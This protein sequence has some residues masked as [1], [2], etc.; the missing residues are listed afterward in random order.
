MAVSLWF[1]ADFQPFYS[2]FAVFGQTDPMICGYSGFSALIFPMSFTRLTQAKSTNPFFERNNGFHIRKKSLS[3][4]NSGLG[5]LL[6]IGKG[7][8]LFH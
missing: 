2:V 5:G 6:D 4:C 3:F 8:L 7:K 1:S